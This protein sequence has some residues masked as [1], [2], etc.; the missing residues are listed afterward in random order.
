[1]LDTLFPLSLCMLTM[2]NDHCSSI[3]LCDI[4]P[5]YNL[6]KCWPVTKHIEVVHIVLDFNYKTTD[7]CPYRTCSIQELYNGK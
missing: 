6:S 4:T 2:M 3:V 7:P 5:E 1:M